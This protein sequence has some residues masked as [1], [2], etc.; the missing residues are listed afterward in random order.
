MILQSLQDIDPKKSPQISENEIIFLVQQGRKF[1]IKVPLLSNKVV[2]F[3]ATLTVTLSLRHSLNVKQ[4]Q[5][6]LC[7]YSI[8]VLIL[9]VVSNQIDRKI[10]CVRVAC[11][12]SHRYHVTVN[13][14]L[15]WETNRIMNFCRCTQIVK[16][17]GQIHRI[18]S[19]CAYAPK[20]MEH[21]NE[22]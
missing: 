11:I 21:I 22:E 6:N 1:S 10:F 15:T 5:R 19:L 8:P 20:Y 4:K 3:T 16:L 13:L 7:Y 17:L 2:S 9:Y 14:Q 12:D 18:S